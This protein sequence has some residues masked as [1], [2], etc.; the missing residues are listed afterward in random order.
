MRA[1]SVVRRAL[2]GIKTGHAGTLDPL[3]GGVLLLACGKAA[4][5]SIPHF[6]GTDKRYRTQIDLRAFTATDDTQADPEPVVVSTPPSDT[7]LDTLLASYQGTIM[8]TPPVFSAIRVN[9]KRAYAEA[10]AGRLPE[11]KA[12]PVQV[13][14]IHRVG[15]SWPVVELEIHC[16][17]GFY[18]RSLARE[19]GE[20]LGTG[21]H[22]L[23]I[24]RTAVG[25][26]VLD[27]AVALDP[28][29]EDLGSKLIPLEAA[30]QR[31]GVKPDTAE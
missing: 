2:G 25:P 28:L 10:R 7:E 4:T 3:A 12:R 23:S 21:G 16:E 17:K 14:R 15:G 6:M 11:L 18:V 27:E 30:L 29:P 24:T 13:H 9:G 8:Q 5:K 19:L 22:C 26:F 1:V 20:R 31:V